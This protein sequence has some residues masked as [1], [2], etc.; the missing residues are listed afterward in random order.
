MAAQRFLESDKEDQD[1]LMLYG[2]AFFTF[3]RSAIYALKYSDGRDD[4]TLADISDR[5]FREKIQPSDVYKTIE[6]ERNNIAHGNDSYAMNPF[7]PI[8]L[9][10]RASSLNIDWYDIVFED[11]WPFPPFKGHQISEVLNICWR[12]V[13]NWLDAIDAE[14]ERAWI[15]RRSES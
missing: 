10:D 2:G 7:K 9:L 8:G 11:T 5:Y 3:L 12:Q 1:S 13:S 6:A 4:P 14:H 15:A